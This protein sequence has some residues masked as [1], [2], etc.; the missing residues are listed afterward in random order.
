[1]SLVIQLPVRE[2]QQEFN[3]RVWEGLQADPELAKIEGRIET[4]RHG[5][6]IMTPPPGPLHGSR[7]FQIA[8]QLRSKLGGRPVTEC[9]LSTSDGVKAAD[10]GWFSDVRFSRAFDKRCFTEAPEI[11]VEVLSPSNTKAEMDEKMAL[12][13]E[14]GAD[15]VWFCDNDG[16]MRFHSSEGPLEHSRLC[17]DFPLVIE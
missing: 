13:F 4:D 6:I 7:Q 5:Q 8:Y 3:L 17:P 12:Y 14:A 15:E 1:M 11:C 10:V 9:A 16:G 2:D